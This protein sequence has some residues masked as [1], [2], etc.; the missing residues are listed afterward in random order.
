MS[1]DGAGTFRGPAED[2]A[3]RPRST[4]P[5]VSANGTIEAV[6][7]TGHEADDGSRVG[8]LL[9]Q[10][11]DPLASFT[12]DGAYDREDVYGAVAERHPEAAVV[13]PPRRDAVPSGTAETAPT[14]RDQHLRSIAE[15]G[16]LGCGLAESLGV[17]PSR[18]GR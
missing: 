3:R 12:G 10:V 8:P 4:W 14:Q 9:D 7:L 5:P 16:R 15:R 1:H 17:Q 6:E 13:V 11:T 2:T 18:F